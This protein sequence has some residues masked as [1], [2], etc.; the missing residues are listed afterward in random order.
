[1]GFVLI[2]WEGELENY[3]RFKL[4]INLMVQAKFCVS[5][6]KLSEPRAF[7][8]ARSSVKSVDEI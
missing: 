1:M 8:E 6:I 2:E 4:N 5:N 7:K 3:R